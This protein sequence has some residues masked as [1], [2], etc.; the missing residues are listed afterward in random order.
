MK[1][2][3][4]IALCTPRRTPFAQIAKG[5]GNYQSYE[6][7]QAVA[8]AILNET[9]LPKDKIDGV[10]V[11]E[12]FPF[13]PNPARVIANGMG[14]PDHI[15]ALTVAQNCVSS[16]ESVA[17]S[18]RRIL[19][20]EGKLFLALGEESQTQ[21]PFVLKHART[22]KKGGSVDKI[23]KGMEPGKFPEGIDLID[24]LDEGLG[25]GPTSF[26]MPMTA[27]IVAQNYG[28][29][30]EL[31]D[32]IAYESFKRAYDAT[33]EG[34]YR[35]YLVPMKGDD[36]ELFQDDEAVLLREGIV[37]NPGRLAKA[38]MLFD[39]PHMKFDQFLAKYGKF[40]KKHHGATVSIFNA[41]ARSDGGSGVIVTTPEVAKE[42]GLEVHALLSGWRMKGVH[43]NYMGIGQAE[44][45][46]G[47]LED[48]GMKIEDVDQVEIHEAF[49]ATAIGALEEIKIRSGGTWDWEKK[50]DDKTLNRFGSSIAIGHPF[51]ATGIRLICNAVMDFEHDKNIKNVLMT[52]CA[53]GG[54]AGAMILERPN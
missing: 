30:K 42:L 8:E 49:A 39:N 27:E 26:G 2:N 47:V 51:G 54:V 15:P 37:K 35:K 44:A 32:K 25:D 10:I 23:L 5:L 36:G 11:G 12:G 52:A 50:L 14:L 21:I 19:I 22:A 38:M 48:L 1:L 13:A 6:L 17:E 43:P 29:T 31:S 7:G 4:K 53:H 45:S 16:I 33:I 46:L 40:I 18:A 9:K 3:Q 34:K 28:I 41:C 20:G 24:S